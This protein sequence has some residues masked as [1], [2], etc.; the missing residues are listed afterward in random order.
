MDKISVLQLGNQNWKDIFKMPDFVDFIYLERLEEIPEKL[1]DIVFIN[2]VLC[3]EEIEILLQSSKAYTLFVTDDVEMTPQMQILYK[4]KRGQILI[5]KDIQDFLTQEV[6]YYF[7]KSY[8]EK[9]R[10]NMLTITHDFTGNI[11]WNGSCNVCLE[12]EYGKDYT[13]IAYWRNNI[14][15]YKGQSIDLWLEYEKEPTVSISMKVT[16]LEFGSSADIISRCDYKEDEL[17]HVIRVDNNE[18]DAILFVSLF[19]KG[20]GTLKITALHDRHSRKDKGYFIPGGNRYVTSNREELFCYFDPGDLKPPLNVYFSGYKTR[21]GFEGYN[22]MRRMGCPFLLIAETR[23]EG[24]AFYLGT[25]EYEKQVTDCILK[26]MK[27]LEFDSNQ[28]I[29][30]GLSMGTFGALYYGCD[31][32]PHAII[33][34]KPIANIGD[35]AAN[36]KRFR[37]GGFPTSLDLLMFNCEEADN[38]AVAQLNKR[39]WKKFDSADWS[40]SKFIISYMLEDDYDGTAYHTL[41]SHLQSDG[42]QVYGKGVHGRHN[43]NTGAIVNWFSSQFEKILHEDFARR[44][45]K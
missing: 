8:G 39:F 33:L 9:Y 1:Y 40:K 32:S 14:P 21:E 4:K 36:E 38:E 25:E 41:I 26:H 45:D 6:K 18:K 42:V 19:A 24:G 16:K 13:Q 30:S 22:L 20:K 27:E 43:D 37:P 35:V 29:L 3:D 11:T 10:P 28:V 34:G 44:I 7:P 12:G 2:R 5:S 31:I 23:L 17:E 15:I